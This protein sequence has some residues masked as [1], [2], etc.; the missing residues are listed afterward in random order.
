[1]ASDDEDR[2]DGG[3]DPGEGPGRLSERDVGH[4]GAAMTRGAGTS[5]GVADVVTA[6][7]GPGRPAHAVVLVDRPSV[8][9]PIVRAATQVIGGPAGRRMAI[10]RRRFGPGGGLLWITVV[11][12]LLSAV[13]LGLG[14]VTKAHCHNQG[15]NT[16]DQF[17]HAC[18]SDIPV[19]Y[20]SAGL[21]GQDAPSLVQAVGEGGLGQPPLAGAAMWAVSRLTGGGQ[22]AGPA[23]VFFDASAVLLAAAL[24]VAVAAVVAAAGRRP[25]DA[26][27]VALAPVLV[28]GGLI[29]YDLLAVALT[30]LSLLAWSRRRPVLGGALLGAAMATRPLTAVL[31]VAVLVLAIRT[32]RVRPLAAFTLP[33]VVAWLAIRLVLLPGTTGGLAEALRSWRASGAGYGSLWLIPSLIGQSQPDQLKIWSI[34]EPFWYKGK[35]LSPATTT[36]CVVVMLVLVGLT[37]VVLGLTV[38]DRPRLAHLALFAVAGSMLV[39]KSVPVQAGLILLP[40]IGLAGLRWRDHLVWATTEVVYFVGVWLYIAAGYDANKGLPATFYLVLLLARDCGV[41]WLMAQ[42]VRA[43][44]DPLIDP[45][46]VPPDGGVGSDDPQGGGFEGVGDALVIRL[47]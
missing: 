25:W 14:A 38:V 44:R 41:G 9:D 12:A 42:A 19:L 11:L 4:V 36:T 13:T 7:P 26:A 43:M 27:H 30:A 16:P 28:T 24:A 47:V 35:G 45:V 46:R 8:A 1:M 18:Y 2:G 21:G 34:L 10:D 5:P 39:V 22:G 20:G 6:G 15:W 17:W 37:T 40:L 32:G 29:S 31:L 33:A 23:R 3:A